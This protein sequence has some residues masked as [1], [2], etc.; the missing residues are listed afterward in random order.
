MGINYFI[1]V[2]NVEKAICTIIHDRHAWF[3]TL[4][5]TLEEWFNQGGE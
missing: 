4:V 5:V 3:G 1:H 2:E